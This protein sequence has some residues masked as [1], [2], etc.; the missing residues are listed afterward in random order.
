MDINITNPDHSAP[1]SS[2]QNKPQIGRYQM[3]LPAEQQMS[4]NH[5]EERR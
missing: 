3:L 1:Q 4:E 2:A 5:H